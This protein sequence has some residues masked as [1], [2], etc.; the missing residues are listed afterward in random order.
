MF[1]DA[2]RFDSFKLPKGPDSWFYTNPRAWGREVADD[3]TLYRL[4]RLPR[5]AIG[6]LMGRAKYAN[7]RVALDVTR[8]AAAKHTLAE[9]TVIAGSARS[10]KSARRPVSVYLAEV[11]PDDVLAAIG[12]GAP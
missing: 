2:E 10:P 8:G 7:I 11:C 1:A 5:V 12:A 9:W 3:R 4:P 6:A